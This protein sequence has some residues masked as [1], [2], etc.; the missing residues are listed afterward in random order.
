MYVILSQAFNNTWDCRIHTAGRTGYVP[1]FPFFMEVSSHICDMVEQSTAEI[2][3]S[4]DILQE[5]GSSDTVGKT[6]LTQIINT[7]SLLMHYVK[8]KLPYNG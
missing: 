6:M 8:Y 3:K 7:S 5:K 1:Q 4:D 2:N